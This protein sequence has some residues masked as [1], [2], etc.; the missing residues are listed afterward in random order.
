MAVRP[1]VGVNTNEPMTS[2]SFMISFD[3]NQQ[4]VPEVRSEKAE[5]GQ[6]DAPFGDR[7]CTSCLGDKMAL[8]RR[9]RNGDIVFCVQP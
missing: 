3:N 1:S 9:C 8:W 7:N 4:M 5:R 6:Q 2:C